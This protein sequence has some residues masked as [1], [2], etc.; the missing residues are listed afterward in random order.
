[1]PSDKGSLA[2]WIW[3]YI[4]A[5]DDG[6]IE[7][8]YYVI[9]VLILSA[10]G[11]LAEKFKQKY[12]ETEEKPR[13]PSPPRPTARPGRPPLPT[14]QRP[15]PAAPPSRPWPRPPIRRPVQPPVARPAE[16]AERPVKKVPREFKRYQAEVLR[17][18]VEISETRP[19]TEKPSPLVEVKKEKVEC[20]DI[21][22]FDDLSLQD[23]RRAIVLNEILG[24]PV[25]LRGE[26]HL[27]ER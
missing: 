17:P 26:S 18:A 6:G 3:S 14:E 15:K 9:A 7:G 13:R 21:G 12:G 1:M 5:Q 23:I 25:A 22:S 16:V 19:A 10:V 27:W 24:Q 4:L 2:M 20:A 11:A 8:L